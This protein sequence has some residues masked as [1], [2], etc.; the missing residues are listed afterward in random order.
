[1]AKIKQEIQDY[2]GTGA[3]S[4]DAVLQRYQHYASQLG[5]QPMDISP[6]RIEQGLKVWVYPVMDQVIKGIKAGDV[7]CI[8]IGVEFI[9][10]D[11]HFPFGKLLKSDTARALRQQQEVPDDLKERLRVR[12]VTMLLHDNVP[13][14]Y[15]EYAKL[16]R[17]IGFA[18]HWPHM[19]RKASK[20]NPY[21]QRYL[22]Y[23]EQIQNRHPAVI[24]SNDR[25]KSE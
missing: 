19:L 11:Q 10:Q 16:L 21:V 2:N 20:H 17:K 5:I 7:A 15:Q 24:K 14:E 4:V 18:E 9:E 13:H 25:H 8:R 3:W 22:N 1:M 23:F 12:I 6:Q